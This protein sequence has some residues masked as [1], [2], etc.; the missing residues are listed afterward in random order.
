MKA[1]QVELAHINIVLIEKQR[2]LT[3][4]WASYDKRIDFNIE[5][6]NPF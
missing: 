5:L 3:M 6:F 4:K 1:W 2:I